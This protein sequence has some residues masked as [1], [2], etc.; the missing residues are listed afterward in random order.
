MELF[1]IIARD[2]DYME[3][4]YR[5]YQLRNSVEGTEEYEER[6]FLQVLIKDYEYRKLNAAIYE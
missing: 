2:T 3:T 4:I 5:V 6:E 1:K